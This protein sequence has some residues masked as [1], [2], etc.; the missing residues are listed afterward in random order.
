MHAIAPS[1]ATRRPRFARWILLCATLVL[2]LLAGRDLLGRRRTDIRVFDAAQVAQLDTDM[3]RSYYDRKPALLFL[4]LAELM[5][6][7]FHFPLL[8]S[9][10]AAARSARAAFVF[11][12][13]RERSDYERAL[14]DLEA[15]YHMIRDVSASPFDVH[16][17]AALE[18]E[19]WI[20]HRERSRHPAGDLERSLAD[21]AAALYGVPASALKDYA[22]ERTVAMVLRDTREAAGGVSERD[23]EEIARHLH[24]AWASLSAAVRPATPPESVASRREIPPL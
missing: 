8:R 18:L 24:A 3:W 13:G 12:D 10:V 23:W 11:K 1:S 6:G 19:W 4:Q 5:R 2:A 21:A 9:Y 17:T 22:R 16:R 7:Q 15:Y 14:P 20:V